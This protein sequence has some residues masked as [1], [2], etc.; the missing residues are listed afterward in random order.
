MKQIILIASIALSLSSFAQTASKTS[1]NEEL[2]NAIM[3][4]QK[5]KA[6][7]LLKAGSD[8]NYFHTGSPYVKVSLLMAAVNNNYP[9][10]AKMVLDAKA[11]VN[12]KDNLENT[13]VM[14]AALA[15]N[16]EMVKLLT[17]HGA[18]LTN[19]NAEGLTAREMANRSNNKAVISY[20]ENGG[21]NSTK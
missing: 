5:E 1:K 20:I 13:A 19:V 18:S 6:D 14:Y 3:N 21:K 2:F 15:G 4:N 9:D 10:I 17:E 11:D 7:V 16:L 12:W 8:P